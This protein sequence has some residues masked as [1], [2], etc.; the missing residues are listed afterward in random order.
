MLLLISRITDLRST[1]TLSGLMISIFIWRIVYNFVDSISEMRR[2]IRNIISRNSIL[3]RIC[4]AYIAIT[5]VSQF[6]FN[7]QLKVPLAGSKRKS[8]SCTRACF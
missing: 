5:K 8:K 1:L 2:K 4:C 3:F 6:A 7:V